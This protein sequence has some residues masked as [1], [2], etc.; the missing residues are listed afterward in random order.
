MFFMATENPDQVAYYLFQ[1]PNPRNGRP[2]TTRYR[3]TL[4]EAQARHGD[5]YK[6][7]LSSVEYRPKWH[8]GIKDFEPYPLGTGPLHWFPESPAKKD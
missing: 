6:P 7:I 3:M 4:E 2:A 5:V 1:Y 8:G